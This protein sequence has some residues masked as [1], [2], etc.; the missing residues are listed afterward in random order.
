MLFLI[1]FTARR[2]Y[3]KPLFR[4]IAKIMMI[5]DCLM[6]TKMALQSIRTWK[7][8]RFNFPPYTLTR[9]NTIPV[10]TPLF[11]CSASFHNSPHLC[12][13]ILSTAFFVFFTFVISGVICNPLG[14]IFIAF[15]AFF[16]LGRIFIAFSAFFI[17]LCSVIFA[18]S[19]FHCLPTFFGLL[20]FSLPLC[21][22]WFAPRPMTIFRFDL[23]IE[24]RKWFDLIASF[25]K[26]CYAFR[27]HVNLPKRLLWLK[28]VAGTPLRSAC[29]ILSQP[30]LDSR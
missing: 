28:P 13:K 11:C 20:V 26:F 30:M 24:F 5:L 9:Q 10:N 21:P 6:P 3:V 7:L 17:F 8:A 16:P 27:S 1:T 14:R 23:N 2:N 4:F 22:T 29:L 15:P 18:H 12:L 25:A 19:S